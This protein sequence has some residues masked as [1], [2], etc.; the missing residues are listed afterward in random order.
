MPMPPSR[1]SAIA[2]RA[3]VTVSIAAETTGML[4]SIVRVSRVRVETSFGSTRDSAGTSSTSSNVRPSLANFRSRAT[5]R[6]SSSWR[7]STLK[8]CPGYQPA[9][10]GP[11]A[12]LNTLLTERGYRDGDALAARRC[13]RPRGRGYPDGRGR[14]S[15]GDALRPA[16][17]RDDLG[18]RP[19]RL[20]H[21]LVRPARRPLQPGAR[22]LPREPPQGDAAVAGRRPECDLPLERDPAA[23]RAAG[24]DLAGA[25]T[26]VRR[27]TRT[28]HSRSTT[29]SA[30]GGCRDRPAE[31]RYQEIA[32]TRPAPGSG[33]AASP[34]TA[35][36][37]ST[38]SRRS[39][40]RTRP[41]ASRVRVPAR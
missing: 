1:A 16:R 37:S 21:L 14:A 9:V 38:A 34:A 10:D 41:A 3:S 13:A 35:R 28:R 19:G 4:S 25:W 6:C 29:S 23:A 20:A 26:S 5:S 27:S 12:R 30:P 32:H 8:G 39:T 15:H 22:G 2:S 17:R 40:T 7:S 33:S 11:R 31:R 18:L 24:G 36:R